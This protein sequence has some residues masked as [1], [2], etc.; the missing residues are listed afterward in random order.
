MN[1]EM[2]EPELAGEARSFIGSAQQQ[3]SARG[4]CS[5]AHTKRDAHLAS[6]TPLAGAARA[7]L[8][9]ARARVNN[10]ALKISCIYFRVP[11]QISCIY[12]V[13][14]IHDVFGFRVQNSSVLP[15]VGVN[16]NGGT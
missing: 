3:Q 8:R 1:V 13:L 4:D 12:R 15:V 2:H 10:T 9:K 14:K 16:N 6:L 5:H 7:L 11:S